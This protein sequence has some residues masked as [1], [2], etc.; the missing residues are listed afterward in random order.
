M[1]EKQMP[2][3][4]MLSLLVA[5]ITSSILVAQEPRAVREARPLDPNS[6]DPI[7]QFHRIGNPKYTA[8][9]KLIINRAQKLQDEHTAVFNKIEIGKSVFEYPG[10]IARGP[11]NFDARGT[12][13]YSLVLGIR[14][15]LAVF[16]GSFSK[17]R[18]QFD[19]KGIIQS[20]LKVQSEW[21]K[22]EHR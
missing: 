8:V 3:R 4:G 16:A 1:H 13:S 14:P 11:I 19:D 7:G 21:N 10:L 12:A 17:Y 20:K 6:S 15:H 9:E 18:I 22:A 5:L 2:I